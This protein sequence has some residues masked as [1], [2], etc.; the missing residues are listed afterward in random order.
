MQSFY[1]L[2]R[3]SSPDTNLSMIVGFLR[4]SLLLDGHPAKRGDRVTVVALATEQSMLPWSPHA[5]NN[6][7]M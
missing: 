4:G 1:E 3:I 6:T 7:T 2:D 5:S